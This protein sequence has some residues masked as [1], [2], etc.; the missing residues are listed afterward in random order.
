MAFNEKNRVFTKEELRVLGF[1]K[2]HAEITKPNLG[3][4]TIRLMDNENIIFLQDKMLYVGKELPSDSEIK[5]H[6]DGWVQAGSIPE[7]ISEIVCIHLQGARDRLGEARDRLPFHC[8][9][10][11]QGHRRAYSDR[12]PC[13]TGPNQGLPGYED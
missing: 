2:F 12:V 4:C 6:V 1:I 3:E 10:P 9:G 8:S 11:D 7:Q 5:K 13:C